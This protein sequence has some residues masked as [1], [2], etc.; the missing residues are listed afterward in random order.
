[1]NKDR[2]FNTAATA[3]TAPGKRVG[4]SL[5][6]TGLVRVNDSNPNASLPSSGASWER[7]NTSCPVALIGWLER[8]SGLR[9]PTRCYGLPLAPTPPVD[10]AKQLLPQSFLNSVL[11]T[12]HGSQTAVTPYAI[13]TAPCC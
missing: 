1:M 2:D 13:P 10:P 12:A 4:D 6:V 9:H 7:T 3:G 11:V 5:S 8:V